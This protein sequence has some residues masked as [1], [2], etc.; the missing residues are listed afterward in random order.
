[1]RKKRIAL[2]LAA[3]IACGTTTACSPIELLLGMSIV[4]PSMIG[5]NKKAKLQNN[6]ANAKTVL[7]Y[8]NM[9]LAELD[10]EGI[11]IT[12]DGWY[13]QNNENVSSDAQWQEVREKCAEYYADIEDCEFSAYISNGACLGAVVYDGR[14]GIYPGVLTSDNYEELLGNNPD[15][16]DA[17]AVVAEQIVNY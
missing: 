3:V 13:D 16:D 17:K 4:A 2:A 1:M 11:A 9:V 15:F 7:T 8:V 6:A 12:L 10:E 14:F 5:Y